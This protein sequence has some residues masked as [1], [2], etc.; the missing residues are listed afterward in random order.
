MKSISVAT[1]SYVKNWETKNNYETIGVIIEKSDGKQSI[2]FN[3]IVT[4]YLK[5]LFGEKFEWWANIFEKK[6]KQD[7]REELPF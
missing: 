6:E 1:G 2:K 4:N 3:P 7:E 5:Q